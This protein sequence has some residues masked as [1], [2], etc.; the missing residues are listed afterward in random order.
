MENWSEVPGFEKYLVSDQGRVAKIMRPGSTEKQRY[1]MVSLPIDGGRQ[2]RYVHEM[3]LS[4]FVGPRPEGAVA[5]HLNDIPTDNRLENLRWGSRSENQFDWRKRAVR[6]TVCK[7]GHELLGRNLLLDKSSNG[8]HCRAC[9]YAT[10]KARR[11]GIDCTQEM[12]DQE[13]QKLVA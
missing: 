6:Q 9:Q 11:R 4:A 12:R 2:N 3:V 7:F 1:P 10:R 5:R 13:F 8:R